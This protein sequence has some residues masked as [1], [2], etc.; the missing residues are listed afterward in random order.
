MAVL[1]PEYLARSGTEHGEQAALFCWANKAMWFGFAVADDP[2]SYERG[3]LV[4]SGEPVLP[5]LKWL[6]AIPNGGGRSAAQG[7]MLKAEG[8]KPGV[9]DI[10]LP[11]VQYGENGHPRFTGLYIEMKR[12]KGVT[13]DVKP[14]QEEFIKFVREQGYRAE[15]CFGWRQAADIIKE[16]LS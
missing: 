3:A 13:S 15:V 2:R 10:C 6:F 14:E 11:V 1:T 8:V 5:V 7:G 12:A 4:W 9:S 16:Y